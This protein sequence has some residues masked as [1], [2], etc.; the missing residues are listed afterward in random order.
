MRRSW[1]NKRVK[2]LGCNEFLDKDT[3]DKLFELARSYDDVVRIEVEPDFSGSE[4]FLLCLP[5]QRK[6]SIA[7]KRYNGGSPDRLTVKHKVEKFT[8]PLSWR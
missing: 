1:F 7:V 4:A 5:I 3:Q 2:E 6:V 8:I